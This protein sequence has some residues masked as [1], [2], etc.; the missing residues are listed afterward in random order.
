MHVRVCVCEMSKP[1]S[2]FAL[3]LLLSRLHPTGMLHKQEVCLPQATHLIV[4]SA[5]SPLQATHTTN[6]LKS[7]RALD[8]FNLKGWV[9]SKKIYPISFHPSDLRHLPLL[10]F[11]SD[12]SGQIPFA[13][14]CTAHNIV[15]KCLN[16]NITKL[17]KES[18]SP[19]HKNIL[20]AI[21]MNYQCIC[22]K[23]I[24]S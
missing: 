5:H 10:T 8:W 9:E 24:Q 21:F 22:V 15:P 1:E 3:Y 20:P 14:I 19:P 11:Y 12:L 18:N 6:T 17:H 16:L 7:C 23:L 2:S 4:F 13:L